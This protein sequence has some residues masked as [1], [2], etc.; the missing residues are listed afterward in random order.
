MNEQEYS[1]LRNAIDELEARERRE[2]YDEARAKLAAL[3]MKRAAARMAR[4]R[5]A[6]GGRLAFNANAIVTR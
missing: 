4:Q 5:R 6:L 2:R 3:I 1:E